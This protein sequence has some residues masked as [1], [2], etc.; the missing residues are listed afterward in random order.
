MSVPRGS[1]NPE[2]K[3]LFDKHIKGKNIMTPDVV[4]YGV[5]GAYAYELSQGEGFKREPIFGVSVITRKYGESRHE[6]SKMFY[7][8]EEAEGWIVEIGRIAPEVK[9]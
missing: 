8:L 5:S 2:A 6:L 3:A 9:P 4:R 7:S 1:F